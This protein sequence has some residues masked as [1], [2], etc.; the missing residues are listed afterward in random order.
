MVKDYNNNMG[1]VDL[2][3]QRTAAYKL[4]RKAFSG[5]Y[6]LRLFFDLMEVACVNAH[7]VYKSLELRGMELLDY[8]IVVSKHHIG[9][10]NCRARNATSSQ[11]SKRSVHPTSVPLH[12]PVVKAKRG[13]C[14][15][16]A[17]GG[18]CKVNPIHFH[19]LCTV[20]CLIINY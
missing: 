19:V 7:L 4:D 18:E 16:C 9:N 12:L 8:K 17:V 11:L 6:Y 2:M 13:R 1:G 14:A 3:D 20:G 10:Y 5:R 15:Y